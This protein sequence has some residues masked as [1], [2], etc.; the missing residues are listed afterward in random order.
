MRTAIINGLMFNL[1]WLAIIYFQSNL[2]AVIIVITHVILH[3]RIM[4]EG[5]GEWM[6]LGG[7]F[8]LGVLLDQLLFLGGVLNLSAKP[9]FAPLWLSCLWLVMAT[10]LM[11]AFAILQQKL[12]LAAV[13]GAVGGCAS[14]IA[15]TGLSV[16][17]FGWPLLSPVV[18][19]L[20]WAFVFPSLLVAARYLQDR[21]QGETC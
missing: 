8:L 18:I 2:L 20:L 13:V 1:S 9:A 16:V 12:W 14:Y 5:R 6:L 7:V 15:G 19:G 4:G 17:D 21:A 10:T 11:H 3:M